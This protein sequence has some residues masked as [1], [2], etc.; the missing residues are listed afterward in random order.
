MALLLAACESEKAPSFIKGNPYAK[1]FAR[2]NGPVKSAVYSYYKNGKLDSSIQND[3]STEGVLLKSKT[4][5]KGDSIVIHYTYDPYN[6]IQDMNGTGITDYRAEYKKGTLVKEWLY[7][8]KKKKNGITNRYKIK[9]ETLIKKVN[10]IR[11]GAGT[12]YTYSYNSRG[13]DAAQSANTD[14]AKSRWH[15]RLQPLL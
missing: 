10:D 14:G 4:L 13:L 6:N 5:V 8:D 15:I 11:T 7:S 1:E 12:T 2:L 3:Y 9:G